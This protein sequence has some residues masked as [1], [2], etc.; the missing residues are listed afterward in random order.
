MQFNGQSALP[1]TPSLL[2]DRLIEGF[3]NSNALLNNIVLSILFQVPKQCSHITS[4]F[5]KFYVLNSL[6]M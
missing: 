6:K 4:N 1:D 2:L 5:I 3:C